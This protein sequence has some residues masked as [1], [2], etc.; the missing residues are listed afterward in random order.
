M[1]PD[2]REFGKLIGK[3]DALAEQFKELQ[4]TITV[5]F[6]KYSKRVDSLEAT[7]DKREGAVQLVLFAQGFLF[8]VI[9]AFSYL[10][11]VAHLL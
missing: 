11:G 7:R 1:S 3:V 2:E 4:R 8:A 9:G 6:E 5:G 10:V